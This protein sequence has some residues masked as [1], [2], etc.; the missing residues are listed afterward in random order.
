MEAPP[1]QFQESPQQDGD[2]S[3]SDSQPPSNTPATGAPAISGT[4]Q[5]GETLTAD[6]SAI[7]DADGL[8]DVSFEFQWMV[9]GEDIA[10]VTSP[11]YTLTASEQDR[12]S[13]CA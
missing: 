9:G 6:T 2:A 11:T 1:A 7:D 13:R 8:T 10:G 5:V 12:P 4:P 3:G